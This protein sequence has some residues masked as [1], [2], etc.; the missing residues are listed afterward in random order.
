M[1]DMQMFANLRRPLFA[2]MA[3][4]KTPHVINEPNV[5]RSKNIHDIYAL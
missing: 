2:L 1:R 5:Q 3:V 4:L